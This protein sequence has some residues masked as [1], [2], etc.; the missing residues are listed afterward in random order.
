MFSPMPLQ[1][2]GVDSQEGPKLPQRLGF[3]EGFGVSLEVSVE[4][5]T[6]SPRYVGHWHFSRANIARKGKGRRGVR[7]G[8]VFACPPCQQ[9][10]LKANAL[11][12]S[13]AC[14]CAWSTVGSR[15]QILS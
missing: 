9:E 3:P 6:L 15:A 14:I 10:Q 4:F 12:F 8:E 13:H 7:E 2:D 11:W 1:A 5:A